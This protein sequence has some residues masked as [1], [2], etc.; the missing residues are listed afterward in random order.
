MMENTMKIVQIARKYKS[1]GKNIKTST[2]WPRLAKAQNEKGLQ[3]ER[4][5]G[6]F[7]LDEDP[8][9]PSNYLLLLLRN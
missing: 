7:I 2:T 1:F 5:R 9:L 3:S 4:R 8:H 6:T